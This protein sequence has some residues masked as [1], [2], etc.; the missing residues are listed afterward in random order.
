MEALFRL[1]CLF[2]LLRSCL[3][4]VSS[5]L[6]SIT[7]TST[8]TNQ[9]PL[10]VQGFTGQSTLLVQIVTSADSN[11]FSVS[12]AGNVVATGG[13]D[14][15]ALSGTTMS[16]DNVDVTGAVSAGSFTADNVV[17]TSD[18]AT[19]VPLEVKGHSTQNSNLIEVK[20]SAGTNVLTVGGD[21]TLTVSGAIEYNDL[22]CSDLDVTGTLTAD[23]FDTDATSISPDTTTKVAVTGKG[24]SGQTAY[25]MQIQSS[26][27]VKLHVTAAG[28]MTVTGSLTA[29]SFSGEFAWSS[30]SGTPSNIAGYGINDAGTT[31]QGALA[32][33]CMTSI[34][35]SNVGSKPTS[36]GGYGINNNE[37]ANAAQGDTATSKYNAGCLQSETATKALIKQHFQYTNTWSNLYNTRNNWGN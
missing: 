35:W 28:A 7:L 13:L 19:N 15:Q 31:A 6:G 29:G 37:Y 17:I 20:N 21:G 14:C 16:F 10:R 9:V 22:S 25:L 2:V 8:A 1:F 24:A 3:N 18:A 26:T 32:D 23:K 33:S 11:M 27:T 34:A 12:T 5:S 4:E 30:I 36:L